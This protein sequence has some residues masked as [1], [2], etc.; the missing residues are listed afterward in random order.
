MKNLTITVILLALIQCAFAQS[1]DFINDPANADMLLVTHDSLR[2]DSWTPGMA[3][4]WETI[5]LSIKDAQNIDVYCLDITDGV[6]KDS[7]KEWIDDNCTDL[8]Y[9][10]LIGDVHRDPDM[11]PYTEYYDPDFPI[12]S[13]SDDETGNFVPLYGQIVDVDLYHFGEVVI[14]NDDVYGSSFDNCRV[15]RIPADSPSEI[16]N[17][18]EKCYEYYNS[19]S[20][21]W[22]DSVLFI[23]NDKYYG[24]TTGSNPR[25]IESWVIGSYLEAQNNS[26]INTNY[27]YTDHVNDDRMDDIV[28]HFNNGRG[29]I[30]AVGS[31]SRDDDFFNMIYGY[32]D[33]SLDVDIF[34]REGEDATYQG[35]GEYPFVIGACCEVG[36]FDKWNADDD[37]ERVCILEEL[38]MDDAG[39]IGAIAPVWYTAPFHCA[40]YT[41]EANEQ[42]FQH[43]AMEFGSLHKSTKAA[44]K[45][46]WEGNRGEDLIDQF[47]LFGDP[48]LR[49]PY[50]PYGAGIWETD[51]V[52]LE[53]DLHIE[54]GDT[55]IINPGVEVRLGADVNIYVDD[56]GTLIAEGTAAE[57]II[58]KRLGEN[59]WDWIQFSTADTNYSSLKHCQIEGASRG[60]YLTSQSSSTDILTVDSCVFSDCGYGIYASNSYINITNTTIEDCSSKGAY[61]LSCAAG[62]VYM[63]ND[64]LRNNGTSGTKTNAGLY[65]ISSHPEVVNC[66]IT[67]NTG[68]GVYCASSAPDLDTDSGSGTAPNTIHSNGIGYGAGDQ[69]GSDGSE[70]YLSSSSYPEIHANNIWD[71]YDSDN[72]GAMIYKYATSG[73]SVSDAEG[74]YWGS[75]GV[76]STDFRWTAITP[77]KYFD[78]VFD[79]SPDSAT[80]IDNASNWEFAMNHWR[81]AVYSDAI[82]YLEDAVFDG[83]AD[84][85]N[86]IH[87]LT[88]CWLK[89]NRNLAELRTFLLEAA[90]EVDEAEVARVARRYASNCYTEQG[91]FQQSASEYDQTRRNAEGLRD[92]ILAVVDYLTVVELGGIQV[93]GVNNDQIAERIEE[94]LEL[95]DSEG[96]SSHNLIPEEY[97]LYQAYPNP[98]NSTAVI[99]YGLPEANQVN[100][101]VFDVMGRLVTTLVDG[102]HAAGFHTIVFDGNHIASGLY[103]YSIKA[104]N[105]NKTMKFTLMR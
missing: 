5:C 21:T 88:G 37:E 90:D 6:D 60:I 20:N 31:G 19:T 91:Q 74:N 10:L 17:Y 30:S 92:S 25:F 94:L 50:E 39:I 2:T 77:A 24:P 96:L 33:D 64:T 78:E 63:N 18:M 62:K 58:F 104:G 34:D 93:N 95:I 11:Y 79:I 55:L 42:I 53:S 41:I 8:D 15:G 46:R 52:E 48:S 26:V 82:P 57:P 69:D 68:C 12:W 28:D 75:V 73:M 76:D 83:L 47:M 4:A 32:G 97:V 35:E 16:V 13:D 56:G 67:E 61:L 1:P 80:Q 71:V 49:L 45:D 100:I 29:L 36:G 72:F 65:L 14:W 89:T 81:D 103:F 105:F 87:Y 98:F 7:L 86:A 70:I 43:C 84:G 99:K 66:Y 54:D 51:V 22:A 38:L 3:N 101:Q 44:V 23:G 59:D 40:S 85:I 9:I 27:L 102:K